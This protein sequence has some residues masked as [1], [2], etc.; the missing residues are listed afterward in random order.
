MLQ[1]LVTFFLANQEPTLY[2][3]NYIFINIHMRT[4]LSL[5]FFPHNE[6]FQV[7]SKHTYNKL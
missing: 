5:N 4:K 3:A 7:H 1:L 6:L 2:K